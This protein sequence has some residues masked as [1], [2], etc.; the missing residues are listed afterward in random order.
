MRTKRIAT[1]IIA[2]I[3]AAGLV[4][5]SGSS[6]VSL[7]EDGLPD[8]IEVWRI[9]N[10][11]EKIMKAFDDVA[12]D[13]E[14]A[15]GI[16]VNYVLTP[17]NDF[18]TKLVTSISAGVY[19]DVVI[20]NSSPGTEFAYTGMV[21]P[22]DELLEEIGSDQYA[23]NLVDTF[24]VDGTLWEI[25]FYVRP[26][27]LH[28]RRDWLEAAG[29]DL[30]LQQDENGDYYIEDLKTWEDILEAGKKIT[31]VANNRYGLGFAYSRKAFGDSAGFCFSV[32]ACH[33]GRIIDEEGN[34]EIDTP[35]M[36]SAIDFLIRLWNSGAVPPAATTWDGNSNNQF[37]LTGDI[38]IVQ[39]SNS[40]LEKLPSDNVALEDVMILP[41]PEGPA[42]S[43][44]Q[45]P[46]ESI[47]VFKTDKLAASEE[48]VKYI[49]SPEVQ[50]KMFETMGFGYYA[51]LRYDVIA[52][53]MF[54]SLTDNEK[55]MLRGST[56][57]VSSSFP[58]ETDS[59]LS[60][61]YSSY[62]YDDILSRIAVDNWTVDQI[63]DEMEQK[64][65]EILFE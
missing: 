52:D 26:G 65:Q 31:D 34:L 49:S 15:T 46:P 51:P 42:G 56:H 9:S 5:A 17:T 11:S 59:R 32:I 41:Y 36:R 48:F 16:K 61:L 14:A 50:L 22:M 12:A 60:I 20:W 8:S 29:Y 45:G 2:L 24:R 35:E 25:P 30:T 28:A 21:Q 39:N 10:P 55:V 4:F 23:T 1:S 64:A 7:T 63:I 40:I 47:T 53:P 57:S 44:K 3:F 62:F 27:S 43:W 58:G 54:E 19:P 33:G 18:H 6:D 38:G 13:F 37:F